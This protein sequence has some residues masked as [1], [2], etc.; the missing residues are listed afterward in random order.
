MLPSKGTYILTS[1][2]PITITECILKLLS[3]IPLYLM[4]KAQNTG[5]TQLCLPNGWVTDWRFGADK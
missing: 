1:R 5:N 4:L 2:N 3:H